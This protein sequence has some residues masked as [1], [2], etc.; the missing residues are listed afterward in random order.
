MFKKK[1]KRK[2]KERGG[3]GGGYLKTLTAAKIM[4]RWWKMN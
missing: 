3:G 4:L 1:K 2:K